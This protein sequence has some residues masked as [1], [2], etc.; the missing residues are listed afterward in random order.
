MADRAKRLKNITKGNKRQAKEKRKQTHR[1]TGEKGWRWR[2]SNTPDPVKNKFQKSKVDRPLGG[3]KEL[4]D[5]QNWRQNNLQLGK[6]E[7]GEGGSFYLPVLCSSLLFPFPNY[8][9]SASFFS[10]ILSIEKLPSFLPSFPMLLRP[11][12]SALVPHRL[13]GH[14]L[15]TCWQWRMAAREAHNARCRRVIS[16]AAGLRKKEPKPASDLR[17][18]DLIKVTAKGRARLWAA[19]SAE[20]QG[21]SPKILL[22]KKEPRKLT[23]V[24]LLKVGKKEKATEICLIKKQR[25]I[26]SPRSLEIQTP[27][28]NDSR[29]R[30][31]RRFG[32]AFQ[33]RKYSK[34]RMRCSD[35]SD[36][37]PLNPASKRSFY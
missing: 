13:G 8:Y 24:K 3:R 14:R 32:H 34:W 4:K 35:W 21:Q 9:S 23:L 26:K 12:P 11:S 31:T 29:K 2:I 7:K 1:P 28:R 33:T 22:K 10:L 36:L 17:E 30:V 5:K 20:R 18:A 37:G 25:R 6:R 27:K 15:P 16:L 19:F